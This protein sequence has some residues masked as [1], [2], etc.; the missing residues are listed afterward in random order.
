MG[1]ALKNKYFMA[2]WGRDSAEEPSGSIQ[3]SPTSATKV[4]QGMK[5]AHLASESF[6]SFFENFEKGSKFVDWSVAD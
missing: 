5:T 1:G 4:R 3:R 2:V 6:F